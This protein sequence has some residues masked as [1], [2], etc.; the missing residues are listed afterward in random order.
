MALTLS[1]TSGITGA[2][3]GTIDSSGANVTG[4]GTFTSLISETLTTDQTVAIKIGDGTNNMTLNAASSGGALSLVLPSGYGTSGQYLQSDGSGNLSWND[5][6]AGS[7]IKGDTSV[8]VI[9]TGSGYILS[10]IHI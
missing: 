10:L 3:I 9:D 2:G 5:F 4:V 1:G 8:E 7:I 6:V